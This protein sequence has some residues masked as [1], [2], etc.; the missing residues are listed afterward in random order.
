MSLTVALAGDTM[1]G[2]GVAATLREDPDRSLF[3]PEVVEASR[4][5]DL[6][7]LNLE[8]C[9]SDR[10]AHPD[11]TR[12]FTFR[13]PS[14][15]V[16]VLHELGV[17][18]VTLANNHVL[19]FGRE[20]LFDTLDHLDAEGIRRVGAGRDVEE[21]RSP[22]VLECRGV[23]L[24]VVGVADHP[25][26]YAADRD[27]PGTAFVDLRQGVPAWLVHQIRSVAADVVLVTP[28]WGPNMVA[29]PLGYVR[30]AARTL[31]ESGAS[32]VAGHSAHVF[33]G[34]QGPVLY[35][36]GDFVD[37]YAVDPVLRNDLGLLW[38]VTLEGAGPTRLEAMPLKLE[39]C[40]TRPATGVDREWIVRRFSRACSR[41]GTEVREDRGRLVVRS[42]SS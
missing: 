3:A 42:A 12:V 2:R 16:R 37:D 21:A 19:D 11:P 9:V 30:A 34:V 8:C 23:R 10:P 25:V 17:S 13:A 6:F 1:L 15:A 41:L 4:S 36:L 35:D 27:R 28:H 22:A 5:A 40:Y 14:F 38:F 39:H 32:M 29:E 18:C 31:L 20:A 7:V 33:H 26:D 24:A